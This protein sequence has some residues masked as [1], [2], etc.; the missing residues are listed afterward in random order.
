MLCDLAWTKSLRGPKEAPWV[1]LCWPASDGTQSVSR[2]HSSP[3]DLSHPEPSAQA[4]P[5][6]TSSCGSGGQGLLHKQVIL[7]RTSDPPHPVQS[8]CPCEEGLRQPLGAS[9]FTPPASPTGVATCQ[10]RG[11]RPKLLNQVRLSHNVRELA[12]GDVFP[13]GLE[14]A[15]G[16]PSWTPHCFQLA[17]SPALP[18]C[19]V[20]DGE[21]RNQGRRL[22]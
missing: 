6:W 18:Q 4:E 22:S 9:F 16:E 15:G 1:P 14:P 12:R 7:G 20:T 8:L 13:W 3:R 17:A 5:A 10:R 11:A 2:E 19:Q 21:R